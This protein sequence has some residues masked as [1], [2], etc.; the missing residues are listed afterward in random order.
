MRN[1]KQ[2]PTSRPGKPAGKQ[3]KRKARV[4]AVMAAPVAASAINSSIQPGERRLCTL[5]GIDEGNL[6]KRRQL[7]RLGDEERDLLS[8]LIPWAHSVAAAVA[9]E[10]Y[11]WQFAFGPT[12]TFFENHAAKK[13]VPVEALRSMLE[14]TQARYF[15]QLFEGAISHWG[16]DYFELRLKVGWVHDKIHL[17]FK[18]YI[19]SYPQLLRI[20]GDHLEQH[21]HSAAD[22]RQ[23]EHA[24]MKVVNYD[25]QAIG[26][27]FL[28][29]TLSSMGLDFGSVVATAGTDRTEH[30]NQ[31]HDGVALILNQVDA[32]AHDRLD[33]PVLRS[34]APCSGKLGAGLQQLSGNTDR[35]STLR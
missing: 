33:D 21:L 4:P 10:F 15:V 34:Q 8:S 1:Q 11:D 6:A 31:L 3:V 18:W 27:S 13:G 2:A 20:A 35:L 24:L 28:C 5:F 25:I 16:A 19:G 29:S 9:K 30:M 7:L 32:L 23:V 26:D 14:T 12:C 17:P 22:V